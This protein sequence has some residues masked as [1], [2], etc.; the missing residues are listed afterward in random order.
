MDIENEQHFRIGP[1][2]KPIAGKGTAGCP[3]A[4]NFLARALNVPIRNLPTVRRR[5][6]AHPDSKWRSRAI[7]FIG[8]IFATPIAP[9][10]EKRIPFV[11]RVHN[12]KACDAMRGAAQ[13]RP[14]S[15]WIDR[16]DRS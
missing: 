13:L 4:R 12:S 2:A 7:F 6:P 10:R 5:S 9:H 8:I 14:P 15:R 3:L 11:N 1:S 16:S